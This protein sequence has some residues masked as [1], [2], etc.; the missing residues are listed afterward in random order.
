[1]HDRARTARQIALFFAGGFV[2]AAVLLGCMAF[3]V[4]RDAIEAQIDARIQAEASS[5]RHMQR[6]GGNKALLDA[7]ER[8]EE[9]GVKSIGH[10]LVNR[11]GKRLSGEFSYPRLPPGWH[12]GI[13]HDDGGHNIA[14]R[15][16]TIDLDDGLRLTVATETSPTA[17]L[18]RTIILFFALV[19]LFLILLAIGFG[20][21]FGRAVRHRLDHMNHA[22]LAIIAGQLDSRIEISGRDDEFDQLARTFNKMLDRIETLVGNL[23]QVSNDVAHEL[24]TPITHL[25]NR[26]DRMLDR[27][28]AGSADHEAIDAAIEDSEQILALF[29]ALLRIAEVESGTVRRHFTLFDLSEKA[30]LIG[31][32]YVAVAEDR[33]HRLSFDIERG[34]AMEGDADLLSQ[35]MVNLV[36]NAIKHTP[37]GSVITFSVT[38]RDKGEVVIR[39]ADNGPGVA[40][41]DIPRLAQRFVRLGTSR[42]VSGHGLGLSMVT[43]IASAHGGETRFRDNRPGLSVCLAFPIGKA[44]APVAGREHE[45]PPPDVNIYSGAD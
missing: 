15:S 20:L 43:A 21:L 2:L 9:R 30:R 6:H 38:R 28:P 8:Q 33:G 36:E 34:I 1:M 4:G 11:A 40:E 14:A 10:M 35:A 24:R 23:R 37:E 19:L 12:D 16:L 45:K 26:L 41:E 17:D 25:Q 32:S 3:L 5:L 44:Q 31:E 42:Q 7:L 18:L 22:A 27:F 29:A 39:V 13:F